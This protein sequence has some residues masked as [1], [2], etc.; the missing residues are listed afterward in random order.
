LRGAGRGFL[1]AA[2]EHVTAAS[3][4]RYLWLTHMLMGDATV[5]GSWSFQQDFKLLEMSVVIIVGPSQGPGFQR[6]RLAQAGHGCGCS[7]SL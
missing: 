4:A 3:Q 1:V 7:L 6:K 5:A 2:R